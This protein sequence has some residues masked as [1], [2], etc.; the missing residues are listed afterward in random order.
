MT[1]QADNALV[2]ACFSSAEAYAAVS[3]LIESGYAA[4]KISAVARCHSA[5]REASACYNLG[6]RVEGWGKEGKAWAGLW[7]ALSGQ[8]IF[9]LPDLGPIFVAGP[10]VEW[11]I[12]AL[13]NIGIFNGLNAVGAALYGIGVS[14]IV[15]PE[16]E[17]SLEAQV[18][19]VVVSGSAD[20]VNLARTILKTEGSSRAA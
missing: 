14:R 6:G 15:V 8:G 12:K 9:V 18:F 19:L 2:V 3:R 4:D 5:V 7:R 16:I 20:D 11:A 13:K 1:W 10:L 17:A